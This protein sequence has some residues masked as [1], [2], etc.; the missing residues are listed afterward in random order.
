[1][2]KFL[3]M[4]LVCAMALSL[5]ACGTSTPGTEETENEESEDTEMKEIKRVA[6]DGA[7]MQRMTSLC[8]P[9]FWKR[10]QESIC[11]LEIR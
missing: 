10:V 5:A 2:K 3:S 7:Q 8:L 6:S 4:L 1:M 11:T 9:E